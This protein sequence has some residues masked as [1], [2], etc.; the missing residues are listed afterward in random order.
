MNS[1]YS[2]TCVSIVKGMHEKVRLIIGLVSLLLLLPLIGFSQTGAGDSCI[3]AGFEIDADFHLTRS[4]VVM[5]FVHDPLGLQGFCRLQRGAGT[6]KSCGEAGDNEI[7]EWM[8]E[9]HEAATGRENWN[10]VR[11]LMST[12]FRKSLVS[13]RKVMVL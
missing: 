12:V 9:R 1:P 7:P 8:V 10:G 13:L 5:P 4:L 11:P 2:L 6:Q 3:V